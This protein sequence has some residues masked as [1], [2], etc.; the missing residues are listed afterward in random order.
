MPSCIPAQPL[1]V[2]AQGCIQDA[3]EQGSFGVEAQHV[4]RQDGM[5]QTED[6]T[7]EERKQ[8]VFGRLLNAMTPDNC[9][10]LHNN[11]FAVGI[12]SAATLRGLID[13]VHTT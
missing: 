10:T 8:K 7:E 13:Q 9:K 12:S 6:S 4:G 5:C 3:F 11:I 2:A 1:L